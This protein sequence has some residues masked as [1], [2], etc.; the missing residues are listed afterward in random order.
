MS[1]LNN[2]PRLW[3]IIARYSL[4]WLAGSSGKYSPVIVREFY[5]SYITNTM[6]L[7]PKGND[8]FLNLV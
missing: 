1:R 2:V 6:E 3:N 5:T 8:T 7:T 4:E